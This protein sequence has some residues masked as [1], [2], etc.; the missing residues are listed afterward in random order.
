MNDN[1][2]VLEPSRLEPQ[3]LQAG[4]TYWANINTA[5]WQQLT[6][7]L[8]LQTSGLIGGYSLRGS[9][10]GLVVITL[11]CGLSILLLNSIYAAIVTRT[12]LIIQLNFLAQEAMSRYLKNKVLPKG[13]DPNRFILFDLDEERTF[14]HVRASTAVAG[15][16]VLV[17][18]FDVL[19]ILSL[20]YP[21]FL[22]ATLPA[23]G[24]PSFPVNK[25]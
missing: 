13:L 11:V 17:L 20:N 5:I 14:F 19:V 24:L 16:S 7:I 15:L 23:F 4:V 21:R 6:I 22:E 1:P 12:K 8:L 3:Y 9:V 2:N 25:C 10:A 18:L